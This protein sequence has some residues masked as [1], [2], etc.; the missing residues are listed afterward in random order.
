MCC[1]SLFISSFVPSPKFLFFTY[2]IPYGIGSSILFV[3]GSLCTGIY[4]PTN[5]KYHVTFTVLISLGFPLGSLTLNSLNDYL[6]DDKQYDWQV[7]QRIYSFVILLCLFICCPFFTDENAELVEIGSDQE[8]VYEKPLYFMNP[9]QVYYFTKFI[10]LLALGMQSCAN[11]SI[12]IHLVLLYFY[13][14]K[15]FF[16]ILILSN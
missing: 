14:L 16:S 10:W 2:S 7:V 6:I 9:K 1:V 11:S 15:L 12:L 3:L 13:I 4:F 8:R 5:S